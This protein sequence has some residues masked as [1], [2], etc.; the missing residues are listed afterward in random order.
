MQS[1]VL[2]IFN[3]IIL[4]FVLLYSLFVQATDDEGTGH[5]TVVP[6]Q[7]TLTDSNDNPPT[8]DSSLYKAIIDEGSAKFEPPL[9][10]HVSHSS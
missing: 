8:F 4:Y 7:I 10:V 2:I 1:N 3:F 6:L 9:Q 5:S